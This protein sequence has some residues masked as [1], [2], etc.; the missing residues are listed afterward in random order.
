VR[1]PP[2]TVVAALLIGYV[3]VVGAGLAVEV[4]VM[5]TNRHE[6]GEE[7]CVYPTEVVRFL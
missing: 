7:V 4:T 5:V 6:L 2:N 1:Y 3:I